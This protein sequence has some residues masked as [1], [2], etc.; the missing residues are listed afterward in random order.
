MEN[1]FSNRARQFIEKAISVRKALIRDKKS[2]INQA[3]AENTIA[4][5]ENLLGLYSYKKDELM[6]GFW[7]RKG[8]LIL[9]LLP[10]RDCGNHNA[11]MNEFHQLELESKLYW[12]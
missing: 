8:A 12:P 10:G 1:E 7:R 3:L 2:K 5:L 11:I 6:A 4:H 9:Q